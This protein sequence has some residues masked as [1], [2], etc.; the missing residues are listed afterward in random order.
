MIEDGGYIN[1][2]LIIMESVN[3]SFINKYGNAVT[4]LRWNHLFNDKLFS[5]LSIIYSDYFFYSTS[6]GYTWGLY[7]FKKDDLL[8]RANIIRDRLQTENKNISA[9]IDDNKNLVIEVAYPYYDKV[10]SY[11]RLDDLLVK[12]I[13][14]VKVK[15]TENI[16]NSSEVILEKIIINKPVDIFLNKKIK[17]DP[18]NFNNLKCST[19][20]IL[21]NQ[22]NKNHIVEID[23]LNSF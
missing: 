16:T 8:H 5:N 20:T 11:K 2:L 17:L 13:N 9:I 10:K 15:N 21:D 6:K 1:F 4:N 18:V 22:F 19:I 14:C 7:Y 12:S 23:K 3:D